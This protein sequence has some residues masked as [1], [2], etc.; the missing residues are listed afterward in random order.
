MTQCT[1]VQYY[2]KNMYALVRGHL[3]HCA[4]TPSS[5]NHDTRMQRE[6]HQTNLQNRLQQ[7]I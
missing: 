3:P 6:R 4:A 5:A 2:L 1:S 7:A